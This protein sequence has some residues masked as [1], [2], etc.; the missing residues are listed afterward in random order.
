[1]IKVLTDE[2]PILTAIAMFNW[3]AYNEFIFADV[4]NL[5]SVFNRTEVDKNSSGTY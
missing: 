4:G 1:M 3:D 2:R 5:E